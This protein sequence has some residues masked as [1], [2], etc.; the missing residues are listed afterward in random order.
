MKRIFIAIRID[1]G[2]TLI[3]MF[4]TFKQILKNDR[5]R[6]T[7]PAN[8][9]ITLLF[10]GDTPDKRV[11]E[12]GAFLQKV[13]NEYGE[14]ELIIS[15]SGVF[16]NTNDPR[17]LWAGIEPSEKMNR[18]QRIISGKLRDTGT[19]IDDRSFNPHLTLGRVKKIND[20]EKLKLLLDE[21]RDKQI[22]RIMVS[23]IILYE[24]LLRPEGPVYI[25]MER[26]ALSGC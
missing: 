14:F 11:K 5:I 8:I 6:W 17:V 3:S 7:D 18:L 21:F 22:Q 24:S 23:E 16:K 2:E 25:P 19:E 9:H 20:P 15:G 1:P 13:C 26:Y 10:L 4:S 12:I